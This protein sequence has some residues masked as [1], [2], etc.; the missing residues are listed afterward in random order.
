MRLKSGAL[1][2]WKGKSRTKCLKEKDRC[3]KNY[4]SLYSFKGKFGSEEFSCQVG[5]ADVRKGIG[6]F[7]NFTQNLSISIQ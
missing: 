1:I 5:S 6:I 3:I 4:V 2:D 7:L